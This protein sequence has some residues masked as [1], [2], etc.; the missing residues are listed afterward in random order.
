MIGREGFNIMVIIKLIYGCGALAL[1]KRECDDLDEMQNEFGRWL[2]EVGKVQNALVRGESGWSLFAER[3][4]KCIV[5]WLIR[6]VY[7]KSLVSGIGRACLRLDMR[8]N[9]RHDAIMFVIS[10]VCG[11]W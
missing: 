8:I 10:L 5:N 9:G 1:Y 4:V 2:W 6:I 11:A 7:D 3:E